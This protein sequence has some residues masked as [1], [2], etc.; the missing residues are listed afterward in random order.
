[1]AEVERVVGLAGLAAVRVRTRAQAVSCV[2]RGGL[3][4]AVLAEG[5]REID[6]MSLLRSIRSIDEALPCLLLAAEFSRQALQQAMSLRARVTPI[7]A[8][9][10]TALAPVLA[11]E[12]RRV[13]MN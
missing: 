9:G 6:P 4:A 12:L 10:E 3:A 11:M 2:E 1:M 8:G 13:L 7:A 5:G